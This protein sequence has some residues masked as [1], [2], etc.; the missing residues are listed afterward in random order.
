MSFSNQ[1]MAQAVGAA[2]GLPSMAGG[3][4]MAHGGQPKH[5]M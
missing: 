4:Q 3:Q 2:D 5:F 1:H